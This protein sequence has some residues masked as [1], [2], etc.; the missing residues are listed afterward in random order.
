MTAIC[1]GGSSSAKPQV[2]PLITISSVAAG[3]FV[4][5]LGFP[6]LDFIVGLAAGGLAL[7]VATFCSADP[8]ADP[9]LTPQ[10]AIDALNYASPQLQLPA[11]ARF[12]QWFESQYWYSICQCSNVVTPSPP[13]P[14]NPGPVGQNPGT[15]GG[16]GSTC[17][18]ASI[19]PVINTTG[20]LQTND[21]T[22][23]VL[24]R[25]GPTITVRASV[26]DVNAT[27][28]AVPIPTGVSSYNLDGSFTG[29]F[30][31]PG[32]PCGLRYVGAQ[33]NGTVIFDSNL[34][35]SDSLTHVT[36]HN[37]PFT[38]GMTHWGI[39]SGDTGA[40]PTGE[41]DGFHLDWSFNCT[42]GNFQSP[43]CPPD[44]YLDSKLN[45]IVGRINEIWSLVSAGTGHGAYV[46]TVRHTGLSGEGTVSIEPSS[47][48]IR[49]E[50]TSSLAQWPHNPQ[51]PNYY[52]S[53]GFITPFAVGTPLRGQRL[54]YNHPIFSWPSYTDLIGY[55]LEPGVTADLV[56]LE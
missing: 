50:V 8:P 6:E 34:G 52:Y 37:L 41:A 11:L 27:I 20:R 24:P 22:T 51:T 36:G 3:A 12:R 55:T 56:E 28:Q 25:T 47:R 19:D 40:R 1:G 30:A 16:T 46:D 26:Y 7:E 49:V 44:P 2:D 23:K 35:S 5:A 45:A 14:T 42:S 9:H 38:T 21:L 13:T 32:E 18:S 48:A 53:L 4:S 10:D 29:A 17:Y 33:A 39:Y 43:C 15:P 54:I 31:L